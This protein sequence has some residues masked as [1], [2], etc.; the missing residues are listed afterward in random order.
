[1]LKH[2][3]L[4]VVKHYHA[5]LLA[6]AILLTLLIADL[7]ARAA[8]TAPRTNRWESVATASATLTRGN[9]RN[10]LGTAG[11]KT[12]RKWKSDELL[13]GTEGGYGE[14]TATVSGTN[15]T[16]KTSDYL[17]GGVQW[18]HLFSEKLYGGLRLNAE[19]DDIA[20]LNYR[21]TVSPLAGYYFLKSTNYFLSAEAGPSY[22]N[23]KLDGERRSYLGARAG[24]R[25]EY[26]FK[27]G[28]RLWEN[29]EWIPQVDKFD[30]WILNSEA[31]VAA[32]INKSL[33]LRLVLQDNFD[34]KPA[35]GREKNDFKLMAGIG[36]KF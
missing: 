32:P 14:T 6:A 24:E 7:A 25:G 21:F 17:K 1:M 16:T 2:T 35:T 12:A 33:D 11:I 23:E 8:D 5:P 28:A 22:V 19:H 4:T 26:K 20:H 9:S 34:N 31:G 18:N 15:V 3:R 10:F 13:L 36:V 29:A 30:N 27:S